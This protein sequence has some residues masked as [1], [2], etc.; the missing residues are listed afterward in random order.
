MMQHA[1]KHGKCGL[2]DR[3]IVITV[4]AS[5]LLLEQRRMYEDMTAF[6]GPFAST[7]QFLG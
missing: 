1:I 4:A 7:R 5:L 3:E 2:T 6:R